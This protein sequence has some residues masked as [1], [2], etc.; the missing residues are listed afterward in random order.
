[1]NSNILTAGVARVNITPPLGTRMLGYILR[2]EPCIG[3]DSDLF[4]TVLV[5]ADDAA[6]VVIVDC[7]LATFTVPRATELR[8]AVADALATPISHVMLAYTH[9]HNGPLVEPGRNFQLTHAESTYIANLSNYIVGAAQAADRN[10]RA[11]RVAGGSGSAPIAINRLET[12][13]DNTII[14][15]QNPNG[16]T[17]HEVG[18]VRIDALDGS[19]I[20]AIV[21]YAAHPVVLG[22][23]P[24]LIGADYPGVVREVV[25]Q[26]T[27]ATCLFL[28]G[29]AGDQMPIEAWT[30]DTAIVRKM[31]GILGHEAVRVYL[32][33]ET[34]R[35]SVRTWKEKSL[36][37]VMVYEIEADP[38]STHTYLGA[39][40]RTVGL[41]FMG[42]PSLEEAQRTYAER[43]AAY[44]YQKERDKTGR[45]VYVEEID[46][47]W[48]ERLLDA[49]R[50]GAQ[51]PSVTGYVQAIRVDDVAILTAPGESFVK[52]GLEA[53][54]RSP[55][56]HTLFASYANGAL[57]YIRAADAYPA[58][59]QRSVTPD[60]IAHKWAYPT[61]FSP[62]CAGIVVDA[63]LTLLEGLNA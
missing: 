4:C 29:A 52:M 2:I 44:E 46:L 54:A 47:K 55:L 24:L 21:N 30:T 61:G 15:G 26:N 50:S 39:D 41:P 17:D 16:I 42:L 28:M 6:K 22:P 31:G 45:M 1:M 8:Q 11:A 49:V 43:K 19:P 62:E 27:G 14:L 53:K 13:P 7:D 35:T 10:R 59:G 9:T 57:G 51:T 63:G 18:I 38:G 34:R 12:L 33:I 36:A 40:Q 20:A 58:A 23:E 37:E 60:A 48:A 32:G 3:I 56:K 25:E 5:L